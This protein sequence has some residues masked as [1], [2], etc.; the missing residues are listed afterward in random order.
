MQE[1]HERGTYQFCALA[2]R[3]N[4]VAEAGRKACAKAPQQLLIHFNL[5]K[6][7]LHLDDPVAARSL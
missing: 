5:L 6:R 3:I 7:K 2:S 4:L 1:V